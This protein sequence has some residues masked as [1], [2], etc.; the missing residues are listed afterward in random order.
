MP[1]RVSIARTMSKTPDLPTG[2]GGSRRFWPT[3]VFSPRTLITPKN[4]PVIALLGDRLGCL[5]DLAADPQVQVFRS[6]HSVWGRHRAAVIGVD[7]SSLGARAQLRD[8]LREIGV[9]C[10][11]LCARLRRLEH[12]FLIV[13]GSPAI[14]EDA[15]LR[16]CDTA[17][18]RLHTRLEQTCG[19]SVVVTAILA[20]HCDDAH[21]LAERVIVRA[22]QPESLDA[23]IALPWNEIAHR[24][25]GAVAVNEYL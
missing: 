17:A 6:V 8:A 19:R 16:I 7:I 12:I 23:G 1:T 14:P 5:Q 21:R 24:P 22:R 2:G 20:E 13:S 15:V 9:Q 25:I 18:R 11:V 10:A 4:H 3:R